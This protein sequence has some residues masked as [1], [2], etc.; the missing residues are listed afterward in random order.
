M[1]LVTG[2]AGYIGS[3]LV[4]EL[5]K[6][7]EVLVVDNLIT[8]HYEFVDEKAIFIKGDIGD[9]SLLNDLFTTYPIKAVM[10]FAASSLVGESVCDPSKYYENNVTATIKLLN[11]MTTYNVKA[12]I[13]SSSAAI[14]GIPSVYKID[15]SVHPNPVNPYGRSKRMMEQILEDYASAYSLNYVI[16]R[17]FNAAGALDT[18]KIGERHEPE[19]HL[20][21]IILQHL[22][23]LRE[24]VQIYGTDYETNDG[25]CI[26]D[27]IHVVDIANAHILALE[28]LL[29][30]AIKNAI[31]NLGNGNGYSVK[32]VIEVCEKVTGK[33]ANIE[34]SPRRLGDPACL[35]A[36][37]E[38]ILLDLGWKAERD[39]EQIIKSAWKWHSKEKIDSK[40]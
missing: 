26:R 24:K 22:N 28:A 35:I 14:Y 18:A 31:Y 20:I 6:K 1:I 27:Y 9:Q 33:K 40:I 36:S 4:K 7:E 34:I 13:F 10:H 17:Y 2:G 32:D 11:A 8:G 21:P 12:L 39:L 23:G 5:V 30:G 3:H 16:L 38:K 29:G 25:T 15:E 19:T 37:A